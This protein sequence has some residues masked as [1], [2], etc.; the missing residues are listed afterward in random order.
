MCVSVWEYTS[1]SIIIIVKFVF[2]NRW[3]G[4]KVQIFGGLFFPPFFVCFFFVP[5][6]KNFLFCRIHYF[7]YTTSVQRRRKKTYERKNA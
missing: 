1:I 3:G 6:H 2:L 4:R 5:T 7:L